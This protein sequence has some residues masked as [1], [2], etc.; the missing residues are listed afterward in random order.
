MR[1]MLS[2]RDRDAAGEVTVRSDLRAGDIG[3]I[4]R[5][6]GTLYA[7]E[8]GMDA[9]FEA[10]VAEGLAKAVQAGWPQR[11]ALRIAERDGRLAGSVALTVEEA[12]R[13]RLRWVLLEP[14]VRGM[15]LGR[16]MVSEAVAEA[17][18]AGLEL[19][20][21]QTFTELRAAGHIYRSLGFEVVETRRFS[22][23]GRPILMQRYERRA[24]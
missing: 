7:A 12:G 20:D 18:A 17:D 24:G 22:G 9:R 21:L 23:W 4:T 8:Y 14:A 6:H 13:G 3:A 2:L 19:V 15:G 16:R 5:L 11:G 1:A 10:G